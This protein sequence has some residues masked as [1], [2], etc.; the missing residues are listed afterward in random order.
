MRTPLVAVASAIAALSA[1]G[2][3]TGNSPGSGSNT[4][5]VDGNVSASETVNN[6]STA[7]EF[8]TDFAVRVTKGGAAVT[9]A[10]VIV[11]SSCGEVSLTDAMGDGNYAG[12]QASY[13]QTYSLDVT[14][15]S[16]RVQ[17]VTVVGPGIHRI[18]APTERQNVNPREA[19]AV[20]WNTAGA[21]TVRLESREYNTTIT[22][23]RGAGEIPANRLRSAPGTATNERVRVIRANSVQPAGAVAGSSFSV[24]IRNQVE[25]FTLL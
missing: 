3:S 7:S 5:R 14:S 19:L 10:T 12:T 2:P 13:C 23:D 9:G 8:N 21:A 11:R 16:D 1:C 4:L 6:G 15:G 18:D 17:G 20:R 25:F 22:P 24:S